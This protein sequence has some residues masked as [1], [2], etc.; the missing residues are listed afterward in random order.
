[1][2][3]HL[4][5]KL[6]EI[7]APGW[8]TRYGNIGVRDGASVVHLTCNPNAKIL[9]L[10]VTVNSENLDIGKTNDVA[11]DSLFYYAISESCTANLTAVRA[12]LSTLPGK[13]RAPGPANKCPA[14]R[15][16]WAGAPPPQANSMFAKL[17]FFPLIE[18]TTNAAASDSCNH[19]S[20]GGRGHTNKRL[21]YINIELRKK[22]GPWT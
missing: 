2:V 5:P 17:E 16:S 3:K 12:F 10:F 21:K 13:S 7:T 11:S 14:K 22:L 6:P 9:T 8:P 19:H 4:H 15:E 18:K 20:T 1:M